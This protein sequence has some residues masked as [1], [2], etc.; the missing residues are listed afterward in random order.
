MDFKYIIGNATLRK[1]MKIQEAVLNKEVRKYPVIS[2][3]ALVK[4]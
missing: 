4:Q 3:R 2:R 1:G